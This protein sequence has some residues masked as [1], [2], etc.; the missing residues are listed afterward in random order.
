MAVFT[1]NQPIDFDIDL[2]ILQRLSDE[3]S[4][5]GFSLGGFSVPSPLPL[6]ASIEVTGFF[7]FASK[8]GTIYTISVN[9][10]A[11][12]K[13]GITGLAPLSLYTLAAEFKIS[14]AAGLARIFSGADTITGSSGNDLLR[15]FNGADTIDGGNGNDV[16]NGGAGKDVIDGGAGN[17]TASYAE[18]TGSVSVVLNGATAVNVKVGG[19]NEDTLKSVENVIG[20]SGNDALTGDGSATR[21]V[22]NN[23]NDTLRGGDGNDFLSGGNG[24]DQLFGDA[25]NDTLTGGAGADAMDGGAGID[26]A[27]YT[28]KT[29]SVE[30]ALKGGTATP[31]R[32]G[33]IVEDMLKNVENLTGGSG[34][35][36]L[37]GDALAN[38]LAGGAGADELNGGGGKDSLTG[39]SSTDMFVFDVKAKGKN[40][41]HILDFSG[42]VIALDNRVFK[43]LKDGPLK[44]KHFQI[45]KKANDGNDYVVYNDDNG[46]LWYDPDGNGGAGKK[47]IAILDGHPH[48]SAGD[49][50][51]L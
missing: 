36:I 41:D 47:L 25:G 24:A 28:E 16:I 45:G 35:D 31:V 2:A 27:L 39:G 40:V 20:G 10:I 48:L 17:D 7:D 23:G 4:Y 49:I 19:V 22:G 29:V 46:R 37:K 14:T 30:V 15:G 26:T 21:L 9:N 3:D 33:G 42:D 13:F 5:T 1:T 34:H 12:Q 8:S 38:V 32:V 18:K 51:I 43:S 44:G 6:G 50:L 11:G